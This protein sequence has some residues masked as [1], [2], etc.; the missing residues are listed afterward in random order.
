MLKKAIIF[1]D[2]TAEP[3]PGQG[4]IGAVIK[5]EQ[6]KSIASISEAIGLAT[7]NQAEYRAII[8]ALEKAVSLGINQ[9]DIRSDSELVVNQINGRYRVKNAALKPLFQQVRQLKDRM[10][11]FTITHIPRRQNREADSLAS[12][13]LR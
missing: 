12:T 11:G 8:A 1:T 9:V 4:A 2:G 10:K 3:N 6:G 5:D 13:T 7:N